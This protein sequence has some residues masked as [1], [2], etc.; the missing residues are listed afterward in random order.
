MDAESFEVQGTPYL[1][2]D[3][4]NSLL[5]QVS[6]DLISRNPSH[7]FQVKFH[8]ENEVTVT[9]HSYEMDLQQRIAVVEDQC[10]QL[11]KEWMK[12]VKKDFKAQGGGTLKLKE[13]KDARMNSAEK[14]SLN[15][16]YYYRSSRVYSM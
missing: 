4:R 3:D 6:E 14:V 13:D 7:G 1:Q 8:G 9:Y 5:K 16:R 10:E 15:N 12:N 2:K 11:F